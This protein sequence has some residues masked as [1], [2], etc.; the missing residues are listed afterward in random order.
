[1]PRMPSRRSTLVSAVVAAALLAALASCAKVPLVGGKP[2]ITLD[3]SAGS[4]CNTCGKSEAHSLWFRVLQVTD[5]SPLTGTRPE[6]VWD[7]EAKLLGSALVS[8]PKASENVIDPGVRKE[9]SFERNPKAKFVVFIG[10][11]CKT[12][13]SCWYVVKP[14]K[15]G[16]GAKLD[17]FADSFCVS[18]RR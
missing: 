18:E 3:L 11:F 2:V 16:G 13:E 12:Q 9:F 7:Q 17:L 10:N 14:L 4:S 1:M 8:D 15:G 6:Q 5:A